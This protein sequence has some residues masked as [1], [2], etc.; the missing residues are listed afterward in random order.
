MQY[1]VK[2]VVALGLPFTKNEVFGLNL[3]ITAGIVGQN[4]PGFVNV[5]INKETFCPILKTDTVNQIEAKMAAF[6]AA[7]VTATYPNT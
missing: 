5:D 7:Y 4:Y 1:E 3:A 6:A 2:N